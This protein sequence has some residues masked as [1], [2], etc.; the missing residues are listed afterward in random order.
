MIYHCKWHQMSVCLLTNV[1]HTYS[2]INGP[3]SLSST[4]MDLQVF[5]THKWICYLS[6]HTNGTCYPFKH[7]YGPA[8]L[9]NIQIDL[10]AFETGLDC[11]DNW[12]NLN[13]CQQV[14][15]EIDYVSL[16]RAIIGYGYTL[17]DLHLQNGI[18]TLEKITHVV[19]NI[20]MSIYVK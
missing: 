19:T 14:L 8:S 12:R 15:R 17:C 3:A 5:Q 13:Y 4:Q 2:H 6:K 16:V 20:D 10:L 18:N 11:L 7:T 1:W 9:S